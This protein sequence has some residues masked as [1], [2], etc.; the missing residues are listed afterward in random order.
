M[1]TVE[2]QETKKD[3][4]FISV[5]VSASEGVGF[6]RHKKFNSKKRASKYIRQVNSRQRL[7]GKR[8]HIGSAME[9]KHKTEESE[10]TT[11]T[12]ELKEKFNS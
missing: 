4:T 5:K 12:N 8:F 11:L 6:D 2:N 7:Y 10:M 1:I 9:K 3:G